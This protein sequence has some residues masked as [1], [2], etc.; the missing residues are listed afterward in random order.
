[1]GA[2]PLEPDSIPRAEEQLVAEAGRAVQALYERQK[3]M[4]DGVSVVAGLLAF[5]SGGE[6]LTTGSQSQLSG[7]F[8][9][10]QSQGETGI[11]RKS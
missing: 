8:G 3:R 2:L 6:S 10:S 5:Q 7:G 11:A 4:H 1:M 9:M